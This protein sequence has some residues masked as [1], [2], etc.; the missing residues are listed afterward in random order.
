MPKRGD[1]TKARKLSGSR[2]SGDARTLNNFELDTIFKAVEDG[3]SDGLQK[4]SP[5]IN[6][7]NGK[8][9]SRSE[10]GRIKRTFFTF[11]PTTKGHPGLSSG[12]SQVARIHARSLELFH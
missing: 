2:S 3:E 11:G 5:A 7:K 12:H 4:N 8:S 1:D 6:R 9:V 10:V